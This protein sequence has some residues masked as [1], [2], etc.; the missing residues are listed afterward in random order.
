MPPAPD[1]L[2]K[3]VR[4]LER[5]VAQQHGMIVQAANAGNAWAGRTVGLQDDANGPGLTGSWTTHLLNT[6][7]VPDGFTGAVV[8]VFCSTGATF[9]SGGTATCYVGAQPVITGASGP[10]ISNGA[11]IPAVGGTTA[12]SV[13]SAFTAVITVTPGGSFQVAM[14]AY[15]VGPFTSGSDNVHLSAS[16]IFVR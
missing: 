4:E 16:V 1:D 8:N 15:A 10:A 3:R 5:Q 2:A 12:C 11:I 6:I 13:T 7:A 14:E 9:T